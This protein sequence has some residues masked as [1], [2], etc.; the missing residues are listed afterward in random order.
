MPAVH[1]GVTSVVQRQL[2]F[3]LTST[4][5]LP[6]PASDGDDQRT[7]L[8][9]SDLFNGLT[10][11][12]FFSQGAS[13]TEPSDHDLYM[14]LSYAIRDPLMSRH[15]AYRELLRRQP[16][17]GVAYLFAEFLIGPQLGNNLLMLGVTGQAR[18]AIAR[19]GGTDLNHILACALPERI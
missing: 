15:L 11:H 9:A 8:T 12:L 16:A 13:S 17:K 14:A 7:G 19:F 10:E 5:A 1:P 6:A 18:E 4:A 2:F 3:V